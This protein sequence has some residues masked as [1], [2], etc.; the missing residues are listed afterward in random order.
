MASG[1]KTLHEIDKAIAKARTQLAKASELPKRASAALADVSRKQAASYG[2]IAKLRLE[3]LDQGEGGD[4]GYVDRQAAKLMNAHEKEEA[5]LAKKA[6]A[7]LAKIAKLEA[8]RRAQESVVE[9][10]V[11]AYDKAAEAT[12]KKLVAD[13]DYI[14]LLTA[15]E[16]AEATTERA[17]AKQALAEEDVE[18]KGA[19]YRNDPYFQYLQK[20]KFGTREAKGWFL[21]K[22]LDGWIARRGKYRDAALNYKRLTDIPVRLARHV[23]DLEEKE[24]QARITLKEAEEKA[25]VKAGVTA[26]KTASLKAQ[27]KLDG[28]DEKLEQAESE[29]QAIRTEQAQ[30]GAGDSAPYR[31]AI[32]LLV[33]TL[34]RQELPSLRRLASQTISRDDDRAIG[35]LIELSRE[36]RELE[37][38]QQDSRVLI[39]KYQRSL[40]EMEQI[41]RKFKSR[42][43]DAPSSTFTSNLIAALLGQMISGLISGNDV[44]RQIERAQRTVHRRSDGDFGGIDWGEAMR[45][46]RSSGG[47]FGGGSGRNSGGIFGG[48]SDP[49]GG[50]GRG[51]GGSSRRSRRSAPTR[52]APRVRI[53]RSRGGGSRRGGFKTG[54]GF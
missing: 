21:T 4:L 30:V 3:L 9:K 17:D 47:I 39:E 37:E 50:W 36:A 14:A 35:D 51:G 7:S 2:E 31:E 26:K 43:Y 45:L 53:P 54:G 29:H 32:A 40:A 42:R 24:E 12:Q 19:A 10:A 48:G 28:I 33:N 25:L 38:D 13:P 34:E 8:E 22:M 27:A 49:F 20:R 15:V 44:W 23:E 16:T 6:D 5:R 11:D 46:P 1:R 18:E 41:R 52:R